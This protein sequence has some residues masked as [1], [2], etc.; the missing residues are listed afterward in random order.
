MFGKALNE[1]EMK[2]VIQHLSTMDHPWNCPHGRPTMRHVLN[3]NAYY[4]RL[5]SQISSQED[6]SQGNTNERNCK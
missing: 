4:S 6:G 5:S 2:E 1:R 3:T